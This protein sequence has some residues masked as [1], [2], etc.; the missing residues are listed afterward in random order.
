MLEASEEAGLESG[1]YEIKM[2][3]LNAPMQIP[4]RRRQASRNHPGF[5]RDE[6]FG[7]R[8]ITAAPPARAVLP[9]ASIQLP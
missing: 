1:L 6:S 8:F 9:A 4:G 2:T 7:Q 5:R 3:E